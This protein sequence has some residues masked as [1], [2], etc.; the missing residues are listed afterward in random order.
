[1]KV[2]IFFLLICLYKPQKG[3]KIQAELVKNNNAEQTT[4][5]Q[6]SPAKGAGNKHADIYFFGIKEGIKFA[7]EL[8][9]KVLPS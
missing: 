4:Q 7:C 5:A 2:A 6:H 9:S 3:W 8:N 1:M